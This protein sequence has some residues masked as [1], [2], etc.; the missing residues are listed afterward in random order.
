MDDF[1]MTIWVIAYFALFGVF[2]YLF[3]VN[4]TD[5][6]VSS[7][8]VAG[9]IGQTLLFAVA[10]IAAIGSVWPFTVLEEKLAPKGWDE[11][12]QIVVVII[13]EVVALVLEIIWCVILQR[14][15]LFSLKWLWFSLLVAVTGLGTELFLANAVAPMFKK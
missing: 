14:K 6:K 15:G 8:C 2:I 1:I 3:A 10:Y 9:I 13:I 11:L 12:W 7:I 5:V 4:K